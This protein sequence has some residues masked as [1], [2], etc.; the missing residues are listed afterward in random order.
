MK[1]TILAALAV[2][3]LS[4]AHARGKSIPEPQVRQAWVDFKQ[5]FDRKYPDPEVERQHYVIFKAN[6]ERI[7][8]LNEQNEGANGQRP[9]G[10][11]EFA[12]VDPSEFQK[13]YTGYR[14]NRAWH[15]QDS[16]TVDDDQDDRPEPDR[17][18]AD[19][20]PQ[21]RDPSEIDEPVR[22]SE[23]SNV[24]LDQNVA[25]G[26]DWRGKGILTPIKNQGACGSC[27][28][29]ATV[30]QIETAI[31]IKTG[32]PPPVLSEQQLVSCDRSDG[33]CMGGDALTAYEYIAR[34]GLM[35]EAS[36]PYT[37]GRTEVD[38]PCAYDRRKVAAQLQSYVWAVAPC[39]S[40]SCR[41]QAAL[42]P[43]LAQ[44][45][46]K[47]GPASVCVNAST[48][49]YYKGGIV[50]AGCSGAWQALD[51]CV[52]LVG[53]SKNPGAGQNYWT[54]RNQWG[55]SWGEQG[56]MRLAMGGNICGI[57]DEAIF[58]TVK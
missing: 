16:N 13:R 45:V 38:G 20:P 4:C 33:G 6:L 42:E 51:H 11:N 40:S 53:W 28:A 9:F 24:T 21:P 23:D 5:N 26:V 56:Y 27:W 37:S 39:N 52:Q 41:E 35:T 36:Y 57:A 34:A 18:R 1:P 2:V 29:F 31:A 7:D 10:V 46:A 15:V 49:Q 44:N 30:E 25:T 54:I 8:D 58:A 32:A 17:P 22:N 43:R 50:S 14:P 55:S 3:T 48:W 47:Y 19:D 12:D